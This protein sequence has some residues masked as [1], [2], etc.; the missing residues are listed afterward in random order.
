MLNHWAPE[1]LGALNLLRARL[2][3]HDLQLHR[4]RLL[5]NAVLEHAQKSKPPNRS[6]TYT[7]SMAWWAAAFRKYGMQIT[8]MPDFGTDDNCRQQ[9]RDLRRLG[10]DDVDAA[11]GM[12]PR[13]GLG[14]ARSVRSQQTQRLEPPLE[15]KWLEPVWLQ[16]MP[17]MYV[18]MYT[19]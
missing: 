5:R 4:F 2:V 11:D 9:T 13:V 6:T 17:C 7:E 1:P 14:T 18:Y 3:P 10:D 8:V 12:R 19:L 15:P 16:R